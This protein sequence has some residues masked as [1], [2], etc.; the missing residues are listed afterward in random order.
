[1]VVVHAP[2]ED[3]WMWVVEVAEHA[4]EERGAGGKDEPVHLH[5]GGGNN[6]I[7]AECS[8]SFLPG[9]LPLRELDPQKW[10]HGEKPQRWK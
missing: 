9:R 8:S 4:K 2:Q 3:K 5:L 6:H 1:M 10:T 7:N